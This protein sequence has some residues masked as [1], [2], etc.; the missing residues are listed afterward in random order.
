MS[1]KK[2]SIPTVSTYEI[3]RKMRRD[4]GEINPISRRIENKKKNYKE[5][6]KGKEFDDYA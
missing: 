5:K 3:V 6:Y 1:K 2:K 4:W